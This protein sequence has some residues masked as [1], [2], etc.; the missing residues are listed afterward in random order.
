MNQ[1]AM[2]LTV[3]YEDEM[4]D[5]TDMDRLQVCIAGEASKYPSDKLDY[6]LEWKEPS[7]SDYRRAH[8]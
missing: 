8:F 5:E 3:C 4:A 6:R 7:C 2:V 1:R